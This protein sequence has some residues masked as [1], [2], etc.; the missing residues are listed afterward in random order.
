MAPRRQD[1][2][3]QIRQRTDDPRLRQIDR[4]EEGR[5]SGLAHVE[6]M[7]ALDLD[8]HVA[9]VERTLVRFP[10]QLHLHAYYLERVVTTD[11][12][13]QMPLDIIAKN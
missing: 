12:I 13:D 1:L 3:V 11:G 8:Q 7:L 9:A 4:L 2:V 10:I 5:V 6:L